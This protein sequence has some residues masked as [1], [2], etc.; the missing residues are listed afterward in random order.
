MTQLIYSDEELMAEHA[1][2]TPQ[3]IAGERMHGGFDEAGTYI[4]PRTLHRWPAVRAWKE[5]LEAKGD[6][7]LD[8]TTELLSRS[9]YPSREQQKFL[10]RNGLGQTFWNSLT[11]T[12]VFE[13]RGRFICEATIPDF[14]NIIVEDI[15]ELGIGHLHRGLLYAH[16]ADEGGDPKRDGVG[17]H[18]AMWYALRD[19]VFDADAYPDPEIPENLSR[20]GAEPLF[21]Q[22]DEAYAGIMGLLLNLLMIEIRAESFFAFCCDLLDDADLFVDRRAEAAEAKEVVERIRTDEAIHTVSL[23]VVL[24]EMRT[25]TF[26]T[27]DGGTI[28]GS[29]LIDGPWETIVSWHSDRRQEGDRERT[30]TQLESMIRKLDGGEL[31]VTEFNSLETV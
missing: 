9:N 28:A 15:S 18:D 4:S 12:G 31:L 24:S 23:Q 13:G 27:T 26:R 19:L 7:I 8:A 10:L 6:K 11:V 21:P 5:A 29:D 14:Q 17:A 2:A 20:P 3:V 16:G 22:I 30:K 1:Y 25:L